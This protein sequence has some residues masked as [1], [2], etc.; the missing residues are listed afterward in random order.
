M[1][2][3]APPDRMPVG[4]EPVGF[5]EIARLLDVRLGTVH[6]WRKR[7]VLPN[8]RWMV[9]GLP[10]WEAS[11]IRSWARETRRLPEFDVF[12]SYASEDKD[13]FVR[14]LVTQLIE[15]GLRVWYDELAVHVGDHLMQAIDRGLTASRYGV[16]IL[17]HA[18]FTKRWTRRELEGLVALESAD[19][20][21]LPVWLDVGAD[22]VAQFSPT[23][24]GVVATKASDGVEAVADA[25][26]RR[27]TSASS[28]GTMA[29]E[30]L[31]EPGAGFRS[32]LTHPNGRAYAA[33]VVGN[34]PES[35]ANLMDD[36]HDFIDEW[37][38]QLEPR[39]HAERSG[40]DLSWW[41]FNDEELTAEWQGWLFPG[42]VVQL[43][44]A[45]NTSEVES[46]S[47]L[48][49]NELTD[50]WRR[51]L[52]ALTRFCEHFQIETLALGM[53][54]QPYPAGGRPI[55][56]LLFG[57]LPRPYRATQPHMVPPWTY[58][59]Y[60]LRRDRLETSLSAAANSL[61]RHF[62]YRRLDEFGE[63]IERLSR[64]KP[65]S[66][67][68]HTPSAGNTGVADIIK[69][70]P[71]P[72]DAG[73]VQRAANSALLSA[74]D[75]F[76]ERPPDVPSSIQGRTL[77][78]WAAVYQ[79]IIERFSSEIKGVVEAGSVLEHDYLARLIRGVRDVFRGSPRSGLSWI[80]A[81]PQLICRLIADQLM[82]RF[83]ALVN[84]EGMRMV[85]DPMVDTYLGRLPWVLS[86]NYR[87]AETLGGNS[88]LAGE[89][90]IHMISEFQDLSTLH[91]KPEDAARCYAS[92]S[93]GLAAAAMARQKEGAPRAVHAWG[94]SRRDFWAEI[95]NWEEEPAIP[96]VFAS[97]AGEPTPVFKS[98]L[99]DRLSLITKAEY[100][101][102]RFFEVPQDA[103]AAVERLRIEGERE[104]SVLKAGTV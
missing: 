73:A 55:V 85:G 46:G 4:H 60:P 49:L 26:Y 53:T 8:P 75:R 14:P 87:H 68:R 95:T 27:L 12:I 99:Q 39:A 44:Q 79:P 78:N 30:A 77:D 72:A 5:R 101:T 11:D 71:P 32:H 69:G 57:S 22:E 42:P 104:I 88:Q 86:P 41:Q 1:H 97:W 47:A 24:A 50:W 74:V 67:T 100:S 96:A 28:V 59:K 3:D 40:E 48:S 93:V 37:F 34:I 82:T 66:S 89:L 36:D 45:M 80:T 92:I 33:I 51:S 6:Q 83:Y 7:G 102:G 91:I 64:S 25:I 29:R 13:A 18:F 81:A 35:T 9:N 15:R 54:L 2:S 43:L 98:R 56:D 94:I 65:A 20:R 31:A 19:K 17:S 52:R 84:W 38:H 90:S 21:I 76:F 16:V 63:A 58:T 62:D 70:T 103:E 61:A 10:A 23:L